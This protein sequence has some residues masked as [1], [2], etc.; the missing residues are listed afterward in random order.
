MT[1]QLKGCWSALATLLVSVGI[2]S[3]QAPSGPVTFHFDEDDVPV[4]D[5][6]GS[7][8]V[9]ETVIGAGG[10]P[11][12]VVFGYDAI[13]DDR[14][15]ITGS[16]LTLVTIDGAFPPVAGD[17]TVRGKVTTAG[18]VTRA[19]ITIRVTGTGTIANLFTTYTLTTTQKLEVA[20]E[21]GELLGRSRGTLNVRGVGKGKIRTDDVEIDLP[22]TADGSWM[23]LA[24][25]IPF[26]KLGGDAI[27]FFPGTGRQIQMN[28]SGTYSPASDIA[29]LK[30]S[31]TAPSRGVN[32]NVDFDA[33]TD[34][35]LNVR[36]K[37]LG[38]SV[39]Y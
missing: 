23:L 38:Q 35:V 17:Y 30:M 11:F 18:H 26:K 16:G 3:A 39:R 1:T 12:P 4:W 33:E 14:G 22:P 27:A 34:T 2:C 7:Y 28:L 24:H 19:N 31:G 21:F 32:L 6:M 10:E 29:R 5:L 13:V 36:G 9:E 25:I 20:P 15:R 8:T 37:I